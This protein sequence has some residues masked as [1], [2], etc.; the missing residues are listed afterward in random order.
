MS[1]LAALVPE[2]RNNCWFCRFHNISDAITCES[3]R[4]LAIPIRN[5]TPDKRTEVEW[6]TTNFDPHE[7]TFNRA[8]ASSFFTAINSL[9]G[10]ERAVIKVGVK[11]R[12]I[13]KIDHQYPSI[14][15]V[16][17]PENGKRFTLCGPTEDAA[18]QMNSNATLNI[19]RLDSGMG[20]NH[21]F[22][23]TVNEILDLDTHFPG[24]QQYA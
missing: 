6:T 23:Q 21:R 15:I 17:T 1:P 10:Q 18:R 11:Y 9:D 2:S 22:W 19:V 3:C 4:A 8:H 13:P 14:L 16:K 12:Y 7:T 20:A 5:P 24:W